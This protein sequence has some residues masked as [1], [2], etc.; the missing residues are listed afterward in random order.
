MKLTQNEFAKLLGVTR[1][2]VSKWEADQRNCTG[3]FAF[4]TAQ[5]ED[6]QFD[7]DE[8]ESDEDN[9][10]LDDNGFEIE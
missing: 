1:V 8:S 7:D 3:I 4:L 5:L 2:C 6:R 9:F 10:D